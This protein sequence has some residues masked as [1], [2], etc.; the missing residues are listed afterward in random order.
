MRRRSASVNFIVVS[1]HISVISLSSD[2]VSGFA[3]CRAREK[4]YTAAEEISL[5]EIIRAFNDRHGTQFTKE[6]FL[7][8]EQVNHEIM[9]E[10]MVEMLRNNPPDVVFSAFSQAFFKGAIRMFQRDAEM[11]N[12]VLADATARDQ[13]IRHFF[14]RALRE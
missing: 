2:S 3:R 6:D 4:P 10:D 12:I 9:N 7:R 1:T 8:F 13:A 5:S 11:K 14:G